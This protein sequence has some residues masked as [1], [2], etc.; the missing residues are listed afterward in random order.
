M[1]FWTTEEL[2]ILEENKKRN[3]EYLNSHKYI[4][5]LAHIVPSTGLYYYTDF[6]LKSE[7]DIDTI[8]TRF[9]TLTTNLKFTFFEGT[10]SVCLHRIFEE[11]IKENEL[12]HFIFRGVKIEGDGVIFGMNS[13]YKILKN[14]SERPIK[15][16][17]EIQTI[18][19]NEQKIENIVEIRYNRFKR[20]YE[21][22]QS[23]GDNEI[24]R[25]DE[26]TD[27][28]WRIENDFG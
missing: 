13:E 16:I 2:A 12:N 9:F 19:R 27:G 6:R 4:I 8:K 25:M 17:G 22:W 26:E 5:E 15:Y 28:S 11:E 3:E 10:T 18:D 7:D 21:S 24:Q 14:P 23:A 1:N 20:S